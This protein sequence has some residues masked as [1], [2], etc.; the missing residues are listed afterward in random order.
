MPRRSG[1]GRQASS[2]TRASS[3]S[4][5]LK[6][7][8]ERRGAAA[9]NDRYKWVQRASCWEKRSRETETLAWRQEEGKRADAKWSFHRDEL[10][11]STL[12]TWSKEELVLRAASFFQR[13]NCPV[14]TLWEEAQWERQDSEQVTSKLASVLLNL[15]FL[16]KEKTSYQYSTIH[17]SSSRAD[18]LSLPYN[19]FQ[20]IFQTPLPQKWFL[21]GFALFQCRHNSTEIAGGFTGYCA[22]IVPPLATKIWFSLQI[23][24]HLPWTRN[25]DSRK[26]V[27]ATFPKIYP[28]HIRHPSDTLLSRTHPDVNTFQG[29][30]H[31][32][33]S[34]ASEPGQCS[35]NLLQQNCPR[36]VRRLNTIPFPDCR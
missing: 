11:K 10:S 13:E 16:F 2:P 6:S 15:H 20:K 1:P 32:L 18:T 4:S 29:P 36:E 17:R 7:G 34:Q 33:H 35:G 27:R 21:R 23:S 26:P 24:E 28:M 14:P 30:Y 31:R 12:K 8:R 19:L 5:H 3:E 9:A 22:F 25:P